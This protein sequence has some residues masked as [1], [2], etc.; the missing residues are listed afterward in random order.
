M[1]GKKEKEE[2]IEEPFPKKNSKFDWL[3][4]ESK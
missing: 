2:E 4:E 3:L 1:K